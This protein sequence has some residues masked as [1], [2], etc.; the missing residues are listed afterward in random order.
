MS[1]AVQ[2]TKMVFTLHTLESAFKEKVVD[3]GK[4][5]MRIKVHSEATPRAREVTAQRPV[6][7]PWAATDR[8]REDI[9]KRRKYPGVGTHWK[10]T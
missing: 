6:V 7:Q 10:D 5:T 1:G 4:W 3:R 2:G 8:L 9:W